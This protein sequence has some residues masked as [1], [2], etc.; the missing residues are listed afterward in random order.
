MISVT[1]AKCYFLMKVVYN[2]WLQGIVVDCVLPKQRQE[3]LLTE[4]HQP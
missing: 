2:T 3:R 4:P 1:S